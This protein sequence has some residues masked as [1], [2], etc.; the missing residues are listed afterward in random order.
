MIKA[1]E[2]FTADEQE[3]IRQA[4]VAAEARTSGEIVPV[5]ATECGNYDREEHIA[6]FLFALLVLSTVWANAQ[7]VIPAPAWSPG[8]PALKLALGSVLGL[9]LLGYLVGTGLTERLWSVRRLLTRASLEERNV[10]DA[11]A[12]A[13]T[14]RRIASTRG[15]TGVMIFASLYERRVRV[16]ADDAVAAKLKEEDFRE[17]RDL[18]LQGFR[19]GR[20]AEGFCAAIAKCG[21]L[22]APGFPRAADDI[23]ELP[24]GLVTVD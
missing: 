11:A 13:F 24:D 10:D 17:V 19:D 16:L 4:V 9:L 12:A 22:L 3:R 21:D 15:Q 6:G 8:T 23:N 7:G 5:L 18:I 14:R 20:A 2:F 1:S